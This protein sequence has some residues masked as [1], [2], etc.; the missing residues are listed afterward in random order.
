MHRVT[1]LLLLCLGPPAVAQQQSPDAQARALY[2]EGDRLYAEGRYEGAVVK[3][4]EAYQLARR[5]LLLYNLANAQERLGNY[6]DA[7]DALRRYAPSAEATEL[8]TIARRMANLEARV[9]LA[10]TP[11]VVPVLPAATTVEPV[12]ESGLSPWVWTLGGTGVA[13][14]AAGVVFGSLAVDAREELSDLC[15]QGR[16]PQGAADAQDRDARYSLF[17]DVGY[18]IGAA[19]LVG[20]GIV[21]LTDSGD[22]SPASKPFVTVGS[23]GVRG[24]YVFQ[25]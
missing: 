8:R 17:A 1:L 7:L 11:P 19:A 15:Q 21:L 9:R 22:P 2:L 25:F 10:A 16:C 4:R 12:D 6:E 3:F 14:L 13:A 20:A 18:G 5:P 24:G 23:A